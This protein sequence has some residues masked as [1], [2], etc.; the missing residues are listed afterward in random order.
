V[1]L[2]AGTAVT[3]TD[4][5]G[6]NQVA[7]GL[8]GLALDQHRLAHARTALVGTEGRAAG[9]FQQVEQIQTTTA[10]SQ[11]STT[12]TNASTNADDAG[13]Y[14]DGI[15]LPTLNLCLTGIY[16]SLDQIDV[17]QVSSAVHELNNLATVCNAVGS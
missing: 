6:R 10:D 5:H 16:Q 14:F 4:L 15:D 17:G 12:D 7:Q 2:I 11:V 1:L 8:R 3:L 9:M 13:I